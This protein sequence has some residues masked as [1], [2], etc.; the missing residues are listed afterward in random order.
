M[1][2][3]NKTMRKHRFLYI[4]QPIEVA[5]ESSDWSGS[6]DALKKILKKDSTKIRTLI[7]TKM[8]RVQ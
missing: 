5:D 6:I 4:M 7:E 1:V 8:N 2:K 3:I